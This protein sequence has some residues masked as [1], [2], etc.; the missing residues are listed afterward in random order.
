MGAHVAFDPFA[1]P[2]P[3][4]QQGGTGGVA[5]DLTEF[6]FDAVFGMD[7][8]DNFDEVNKEKEGD[9][10]DESTAKSGRLLFAE[11]MKDG[12]D[13]GADQYEPEDAAKRVGHAAAARS[14]GDFD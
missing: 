1:S 7:N 9:D 10:G 13:N 4:G 12:D 6:D 2:D 8:L 5:P 14:P 11:S 3:P